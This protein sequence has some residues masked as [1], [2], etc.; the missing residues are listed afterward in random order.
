MISVC[1]YKNFTFLHA[2]LTPL[3]CYTLLQSHTHN[4]P[5]YLFAHVFPPKFSDYFPFLKSNFHFRFK[6]EIFD[7][8]LDME[9]LHVLSYYS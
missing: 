6:F 8:Q 1:E 5:T 9:I 7:Y 4:W 2:S 3:W